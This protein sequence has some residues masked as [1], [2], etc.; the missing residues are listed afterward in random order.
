MQQ[1]NEPLFGEWAEP[2]PEPEEDWGPVELEAPQVETKSVYLRAADL[3]SLSS[4]FLIIPD[5]N[6]DEIAMRAMADLL[7]MN[8]KPGDHGGPAAV[9][10]KVIRG[11]RIVFTRDAFWIYDSVLGIWVEVPQTALEKRIVSYRQVQFGKPKTKVIDGEEVKIYKRLRMSGSKVGSAAKLARTLVGREKFFEAAPVGLHFRDQ[12]LEHGPQ[13]W[14]KADRGPAIRQRHVYP[15]SSPPWDFIDRDVLDPRWEQVCPVLYRVLRSAMP[16]RTEDWRAIRQRFGLAL[17]GMS[18]KVRG[19]HLWFT[20][21]PGCGKSSIAAAFGSLFPRE[22][23]TAVEIHDAKEWKTGKLEVSRYNVV[24][25]C[26]AVKTPDFMKN[27][28]TG[29]DDGLL[30]VRDQGERALYITPRFMAVMCSNGKPVIP[31]EAVRAIIDRFTVIRFEPFK[32]RPDPTIATQ[33][34]QQA[35][36]LVEWAMA[37]LYDWQVNGLV[38]SKESRIAKLAWWRSS[39]NV[40][41]WAAAQLREAEGEYLPIT[42]PKLKNGAFEAYLLWCEGSNVPPRLRKT[43]HEFMRV[44]KEE[45]GLDVRRYGKHN[46]TSLVNFRLDRP[47]DEPSSPLNFVPPCK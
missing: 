32:G 6:C 12:F 26:E 41:L 35:R 47:V 40:L 9:E 4:E 44:L 39:N 30:E 16:E 20:G 45:M 38:E 13:G 29:L 19:A 21:P 34:E 42:Q 18:Q 43:S 25:E 17:A 24:G 8:E 37:G 1:E 46:K 22:N 33:M 27:C 11:G 36:G 15:F 28:L 7:E 2:E 23:R 5:D 31:E 10:S 3:P 14:V